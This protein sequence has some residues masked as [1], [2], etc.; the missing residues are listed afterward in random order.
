MS[1]TF[2][3]LKSRVR[4]YVDRTDIDTKIE[5][6]I[7]DT[8][9]DISTKYNF[10]YLY[11]EATVSTV[12]GSSYYPYPS[13]YLDKLAIFCGG[14]KLSK[15][16]AHF[17]EELVSTTS[18]G[19]IW[20]ASGDPIYYIE[21]G[22]EFQL[23]PTP[24][25][26]YTLDLRYYAQP[27]DFTASGDYDDMSN[28]Y[29]DAIIYGACERAAIYL[30]DDQGEAKF[31]KRYIDKIQELIANEKRQQD[32]TDNKMK[33]IKTVGDYSKTQLANFLKID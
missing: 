21:R 17:F 23:Y 24:D 20:S 18:T 12:A 2:D 26:V 15:V 27:A 11:T 1:F 10:H 31:H 22:S 25:A 8:R 28:L 19:D 4:E 7:N 16:P 6:W 5:N 30:E 9:R 3:S 33:R 13:D 32:M 14:R 29:P